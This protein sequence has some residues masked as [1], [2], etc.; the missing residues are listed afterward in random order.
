MITKKIFAKQE[1]KIAFGTKEEKNEIKKILTKKNPL[2][3]QMFQLYKWIVYFIILK[4]QQKQKRY[5]V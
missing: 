4:K 3:K 2:K 5:S 1:K